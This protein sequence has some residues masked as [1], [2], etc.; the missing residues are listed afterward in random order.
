MNINSIRSLLYTSAKHLG[1]IQAVSKAVS[2]KSASPIVKRI[3]RRIY[4]KITSN[5]FNL[6]K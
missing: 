5:V 2:K 1:D 6:L 4:G 3:V